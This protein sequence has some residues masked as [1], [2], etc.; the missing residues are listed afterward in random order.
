MPNDVQLSLGDYRFGLENAAY[1]QIPRAW[2]W[3]WVQQDVLV[4]RPFQFNV[5]ARV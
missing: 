2:V 5:R 1:E 3:R 4:A